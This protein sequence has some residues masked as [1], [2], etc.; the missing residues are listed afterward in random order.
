MQVSGQF[1][2]VLGRGGR[3]VHEWHWRYTVLVRRRQTVDVGLIS[4]DVGRCMLHCPILAPRRVGHYDTR[5]GRALSRV[6]PLPTPICWS[7][8]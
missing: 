1:V 3:P 5:R 6:T 2:K 7:M 4:L 8:H